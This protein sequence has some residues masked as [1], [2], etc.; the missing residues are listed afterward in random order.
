MY[1]G[2]KIILGVKDP[3]TMQFFTNERQLNNKLKKNV[4][5]QMHTWKSSEVRKQSHY[6]IRLDSLLRIKLLSHLFS[7]D[8]LCEHFAH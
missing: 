3:L 5:P 4:G 6:N 2:P 8:H 7:F 1:T